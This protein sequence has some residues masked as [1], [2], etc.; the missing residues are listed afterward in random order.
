[1]PKVQYLLISP[2]TGPI[3]FLAAPALGM[4]LWHKA[5]ESQVIAKHNSLV[6][7]GDQDVF[8]SAKKISA[9]A[10]KMEAESGSQV[11]HVLVEGAG[12]FWT[13]RGVEEELR[14]AMR[15]WETER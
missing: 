2:L 12:H 3:S 11:S 7:Y 14:Q 13:E 1:M 5:H 10:K 15:A 6:V 4:R 9:W 8:A